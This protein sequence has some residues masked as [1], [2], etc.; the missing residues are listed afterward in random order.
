VSWFGDSRA[1]RRNLWGGLVLAALGA[2]MAGLAAGGLERA[3]L[4]PGSH[5]ND[6]IQL[7]LAVLLVFAALMQFRLGLRATPFPRRESTAEPRSP[8]HDPTSEIP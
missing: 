8:H 3:E 5:R 6:W 4:F 1:P 7:A 2:F